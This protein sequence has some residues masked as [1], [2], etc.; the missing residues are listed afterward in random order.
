MDSKT[1]MN[2]LEKLEWRNMIPYDNLYNGTPKLVDYS[3][4]NNLSEKDICDIISSFSSEAQKNSKIEGEL[5]PN[6][7]SKEKENYCNDKNIQ[8][9]LIDR[10]KG[11]LCGLAIADSVGAPLEFKNVLSTH[12]IPNG[13]GDVFQREESKPAT[14][15]NKPS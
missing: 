13:K 4:F 2:I 15:E 1:C 5:L 9:V 12:E 6:G 14:L 11:S 10:V 8:R 3:I 7:N